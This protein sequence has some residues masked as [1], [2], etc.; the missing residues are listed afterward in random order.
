VKRRFDVVAMLPVLILM[1]PVMDTIA[2][3]ARLSGPCPVTFRQCR[4]GLDGRRTLMKFR[5]LP[6]NDDGDRTWSVVHD[7]PV[8]KLGGFLR[9]TGLGEAP[10]QTLTERIVILLRTAGLFLRQVLRAPLH[11][12]AKARQRL[13]PAPA[14]PGTVTSATATPQP[15]K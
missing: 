3:A 1:S 15:A 13:S 2:A 11:T 6:P 4:V 9:P 10:E 12:T 5:T 8:G 14:T 7:P